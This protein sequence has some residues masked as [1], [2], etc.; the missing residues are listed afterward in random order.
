LKGGGE[1][2]R[3]RGKKGTKRAVLSATT[4]EEMINTAGGLVGERGNGTREWIRK[5]SIMTDA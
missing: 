2:E 4:M 3:G 1:N 5:E